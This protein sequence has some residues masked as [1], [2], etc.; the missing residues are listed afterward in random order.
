VAPRTKS[1]TILGPKAAPHSKA[2]PCSDRKQHRTRKPH[3]GLIEKMKGAPQA[4]HGLDMRCI[5]CQHAFEQPRQLSHSF[6]HMCL[7]WP[8]AFCSTEHAST[9]H[10]AQESRVRNCEHSAQHAASFQ[11]VHF[12]DWH[13]SALKPKLAWKPKLAR[14]P[15]L[16]HKPKLARKPKLA[17]V[18]PAL[19]KCLS[20]PALGYACHYSCRFGWKH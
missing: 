14:K 5:H 6:R 16:A 4:L 11:K 17:H 13:P 20:G 9:A 7:S 15:K 19:C 12:L 8:L 18:K 10:S 3:H 1:G 2:T